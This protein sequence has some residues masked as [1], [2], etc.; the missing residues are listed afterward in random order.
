M[1]KNKERVAGVIWET[2]KEKKWLSLGIVLA[3][4][5]AVAASV[6]PPLILGRIID[7]LTAGE[8]IRFASA[9][10]YFALDELVEV[11]ERGARFEVRHA[12]VYAVCERHGVDI[13]NVERAFWDYKFPACGN[14]V[15]ASVGEIV[16]LLNEA[17]DYDVVVRVLREPE[18]YFCKARA[19]LKNFYLCF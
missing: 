7:A 4:G 11:L 6:F 2:V 8:G 13:R 14:Y 16:A 12:R 1:K 5:G 15:L 10:A 9:A 18:P 19:H 17:R 3:V